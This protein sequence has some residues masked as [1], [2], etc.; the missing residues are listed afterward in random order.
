MTFDMARTLL[1]E[2][3]LDASLDHKE[4]KRFIAQL[5]GEVCLDRKLGERCAVRLLE[6]FRERIYGLHD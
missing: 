3:L 6:E 5:I 4:K 1:M 2:R